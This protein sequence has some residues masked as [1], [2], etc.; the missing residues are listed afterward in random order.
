MWWW[1]YQLFKFPPCE[2]YVN[3]TTTGFV[4]QYYSSCCSKRLSTPVLL[5][6]MLIGRLMSPQAVHS[7]LLNS[8][9]SFGHVW[10]CQSPEAPQH[11][12]GSTCRHTQCVRT[13]VCVCLFLNRATFGDTSDSQSTGD[14]W[15]KAATKTMWKSGIVVKMTSI[16]W[17]LSSQVTVKDK[18]IK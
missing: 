9:N 4:L 17:K 11:V 16:N 2:I 18:I 5:S 15:C 3:N 14:L 7:D 8:Q 1:C 13:C 10:S 6:G 12:D